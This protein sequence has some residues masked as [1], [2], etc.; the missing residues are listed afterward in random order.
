MVSS[1][2]AVDVFN[3]QAANF[4][5][6][7]G[8]I[9][10]IARPIFNALYSRVVHTKPYELDAIAAVAAYTYTEGNLSA[11]AAQMG[12]RQFS[13]TDLSVIA[14]ASLAL[15]RVSSFSYELFDGDAEPLIRASIESARARF[16]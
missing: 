8:D 3:N 14:S 9:A 16:A 11:L 13:E 15:L 6:Q 4:S 5:A 1:Q 2:N 10:V 12:D 7:R